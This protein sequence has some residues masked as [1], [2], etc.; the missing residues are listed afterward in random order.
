[1][2]REGAHKRRG[3]HSIFHIA[4]IFKE[5]PE[6]SVVGGHG[7]IAGGELAGEQR[8]LQRIELT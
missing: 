5:H 8:M 7:E 3:T 4:V 1:M 2:K 6:G